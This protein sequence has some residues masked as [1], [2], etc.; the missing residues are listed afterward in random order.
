MKPAGVSGPTFALLGVGLVIVGLLAGILGMLAFGPDRNGDPG[1]ARIV[2]R[3]QLGGTPSA[4]SIHGDTAD[5]ARDLDPI[6]LNSY[7]RRVAER[8]TPAVVFIQVEARGQAE[9]GGE[10]L[11]GDREQRRRFFR[12]RFPRQSVGSGVIISDQG[13]V[14]TNFHV[15]DGADRIHVTLADKRQFEA[16][17][18]GTDPSTDLAVLKIDTRG[19]T[20]VVVLGNSDNLSVGEWVLAVG[21]PFRLTSTVTAGIVSALGRQVNIIDDTFRIEDFI[22]TDAA[23]NPGNSGGA[24]VNLE[25]ELIGIN[26]AIATESGSYEGYGFAVP[27]NLME[28]VVSDLIA[29]GDVRRGFLGVTIG[30]VDARTANRI[31]LARIGGVF[32]NEVTPG[33]AADRAGLKDGD[34]VLSISGRPVNAPNEL[35]SVVA[36]YRPGESLDLEVWRG[37]SLLAMN[38]ELLARESPAYERWFAE[39][40]RDTA[41]PRMPELQPESDEATSFNIDIYGIGL[42]ELNDRDRRSFEVRHGAYVA[43][44]ITGRPAAAGGLPRDAVIINI[45]SED[46]YSAEDAIRQFELAADASEPALVQIKRRDGLYGF[47]E[48]PAP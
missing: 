24:L 8:V 40:G 12:E 9:V 11:H 34:V 35:Q 19:E 26:T 25:G 6:T 31:G 32:V 7:F 33:G 22:Q 43:Y 5:I 17:V 29:Y 37:G 30:D 38:V 23:I 41:P 47:Y 45:D 20:P 2:E 48:I 3:V 28:R 10:W 1:E 15:I 21:N 16:A 44:T 36:R 39:L 4:T 18:V 14:V 42:R 27:V 13:H 46:I